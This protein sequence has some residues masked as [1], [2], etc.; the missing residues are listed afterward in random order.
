MGDIRS[1]IPHGPRFGAERVRALAALAVLVALMGACSSRVGD[2]AASMTPSPR[3][4]PS[5]AAP[6]EPTQDPAIAI[7]TPLENGEVSSPVSVTGTADVEGNEVVVRVLDG[8]GA[9]LAAVVVDVRCKR[10]CPGTF[11]TELSFFVERRE[12]GTIAVSGETADGP[13]SSTMPVV[14]FPV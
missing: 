1:I 3:P 11:A 8:A 4:S 6:A 7:E 10:G 13:T 9:E 2:L 5:A 14:L 12:P